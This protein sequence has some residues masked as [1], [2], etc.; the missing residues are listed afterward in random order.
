MYL[1]YWIRCNTDISCTSMIGTPIV[2]NL[3]ILVEE[4]VRAYGRPQLVR[5]VSYTPP[6][7]TT[8]S[9]GVLDHNDPS[10]CGSSSSVLVLFVCA[11]VQ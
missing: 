7:Q 3:N 5:L 9:G 8:P 11:N 10:S 1:M 4:T 6:P 2:K